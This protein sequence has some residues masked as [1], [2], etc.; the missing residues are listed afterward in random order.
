[1]A[2]HTAFDQTAEYQLLEAGS[3]AA[4]D[5]IAES[6]SDAF[7]AEGGET[8]WDL[9]LGTQYSAVRDMRVP[10]GSLTTEVQNIDLMAYGKPASA[11][12]LPASVYAMQGGIVNVA[13][14]ATKHS[15]CYIKRLE[16][17]CAQGG[18]LQCGYQWNALAEDPTITIAEA[19]AKQ[20]NS[21]IAWH[22][23]DAELALDGAAAA[24][25]EIM[26]WRAI[27]ENEFEA[28]TSQDAKEAGSE[29]MPE[30]YEVTGPTVVSV[31]LTYRVLQGI[32]LSLVAGNYIDFTWAAQDTEET[33]KTFTY[34]SSGGSG[35][36][37]QSNPRPIGKSHEAVIYSVNARSAPWDLAAWGVTFAA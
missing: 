21:P 9:G 28:R 4:F 17:S 22:A 27:L 7:S 32:D 26:S 37:V 30:W 8:T 18:N 19:A 25:V 20:T 23:A 35:L 15:T 10:I 1:M 31:E 3:M 6:A 14:G 24:G 34:D 13:G 12:A 16:L 33:P 11:G 5:R 2:R 36:I 29:L